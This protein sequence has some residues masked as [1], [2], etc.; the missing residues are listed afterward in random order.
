MHALSL[1]AHLHTAC[2]GSAGSQHSLCC[3]KQRKLTAAVVSTFR[4]SYT[5]AHTS[6]SCTSC[7]KML[8]LV[9][10]A[11]AVW[12]CACMRPVNTPADAP[13]ATVNFSQLPPA[14]AVVLACG[15]QDDRF[16]ITKRCFE[17]QYAQLY[18]SRLML[19][20][21]LMMQQVQQAWPNTR[22]GPAL[23]CM[24]LVRG[25]S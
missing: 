13:P 3:D 8:M 1:S 5:P 23:C 14:A 17:R 11:V 18:F 10:P 12:L 9:L 22:G 15:C 25:I 7:R 19:L 4:A 6:C 24:M 2:M 20:Q 21:P 16:L